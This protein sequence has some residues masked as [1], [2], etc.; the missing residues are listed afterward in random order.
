M[1][2]KVLSVFFLGIIV[3]FKMFFV[4]IDLVMGFDGE[5]RDVFGFITFLGYEIGCL[6]IFIERVKM[7]K[8]GRKEGL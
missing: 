8:E 5:C 6:Y 7:K 3:W 2:Y 1:Y 4:E